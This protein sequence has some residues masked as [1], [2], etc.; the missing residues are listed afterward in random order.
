MYRKL[1]ICLLI[2]YLLPIALLLWF[3]THF[4]VN[5]PWMDDWALASLFEKVAMGKATFADFFAQHNEHRILFPKLIFVILAFASKWDVRLEIFFSIFLAIVIFISLYKIASNPPNQ[6]IVLLHIV[7]V[8]TCI[9]TFSLVQHENWLWGFQISWFLINACVTLAIFIITIP[10]KCNPNLRLPISALCCFIASFSSAHGLLSW[11][12][13]IPSVASLEG[14]VRQRII[15]VVLWIILFTLCFAIYSIG[16]KKPG[17]HPDTFFFLKEPLKAGI[18]LLT[19]IGSSIGKPSAIIG[20][21]ILL[22]F[23]VFNIY[24][25]QNYK[26]EF[27]CNAAPWLSLGWFATLFALITTVGRAGFGVEQATASRYTT[28]LILLVIATLQMWKL[29]I[30]QTEGSIN[31]NISL[32]SGSS[33]L[34]GVFAV[35]FVGNSLTAIAQAEQISLQKKMGNTCLDVSSFIDK[36]ISNLT[37]NCLKNLFPNPYSLKAFTKSV[38]KAGFRNFPQDLAFINESSKPYGY[39]DI[40]PTTNSILTISRSVSLQM[41]GWGIIPNQSKQP[42]IVWLSYGDK[43]SLFA[44]ALIQL[45]RPDVAK[46]LNSSL[47]TKVGWIANIPLTNLPLGETVI[48][49]WVYDSDN[50][51]FVKLNGEPKIK[52]VE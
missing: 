5:V 30:C 18:Y 37:D 24:S 43:Q 15:R 35:F 4:S 39:I 20:S 46:A 7:N 28:V 21:I 52:V 34:A 14:K 51:Q 6:N 9:L 3:V 23:L 49:A 29:F 48:K 38:E 47:Y 31:K 32:I 40:P 17:Y 19:I 45:D 10:Q 2:T 11:L 16:Y 42:N 50:K 12:A 22:I 25:L 41:A 8:T 13:I 26:S 27:T 1:K 44:N 33:F 36:S